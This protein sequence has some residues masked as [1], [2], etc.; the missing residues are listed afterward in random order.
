MKPAIIVLNLL[1][2]SQL[3]F[4]QNK[5]SIS[6]DDVPNTRLYEKDLYE[7]PL[8]KK[9]NA[10][11]IPI[12]IYINEGNIYK[13][14]S[15]RR[16]FELLSF[17][18]KKDFVTLGNHSFNHSRYSQVGLD[19]FKLDIIKGESISSELAKKY[20]KD[21]RHFRFPYN[22]LGNDSAQ[23][24]KIKQFLNKRDYQI[25]PFTIESSDWMYNRV[26]EYY[27]NQNNLARAKQIGQA[28]VTITLEYFTFF[29]KFCQKQYGRSINHI[30]LCHDNKLNADY[31]DQIVKEL[32][33]KEYQFI[34][35]DEALKD[36]VYKQKDSYYKKWGIS[37]LYRWQ[38]SQKDRI[39]Y[40]KLE[41]STKEIED[42]F[43][44]INQ[45]KNKTY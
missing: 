43:K 19:S 27:L 34:S 21:L 38:K 36:P 11:A 18:A 31:L 23:H 37:W 1:I 12:A 30:Y 40:M 45:N 9:L 29:E 4:T 28:Y 20:K 35:L 6:I 25:S 26:Y 10:L 15:I 44:Q 13:T 8:L 14:D 2:L 3:G 24:V 32:K 39:K 16:N 7:S 17:W 22:D 42:L 41:P 5:V 33:Q